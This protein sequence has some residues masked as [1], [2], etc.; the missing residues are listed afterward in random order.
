MSPTQQRQNE[1]LVPFF[2][3]TKTQT[4]K[5]VPATTDCTPASHYGCVYCSFIIVCSSLFVPCY[6]L[7]FIVCSF[8]HCCLFV[9]CMVVQCLFAVCSS[10]VHCSFIVPSFIVSSYIVCSFIVC[11]FIIVYLSL[12]I[13]CCSFIVCLFIVRI[14]LNS[15]VLSLFVCLFVCLFIGV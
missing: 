4:Q 12:F 5:T 11:L 3:V 6:R 14:Y 13:Y 2:I 10:F 8:V 1:V 7:L 15:F 9:H